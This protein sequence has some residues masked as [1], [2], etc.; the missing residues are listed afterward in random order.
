MHSDILFEKMDRTI[1]L[2]KSIDSKLPD[3]HTGFCFSD[4]IAGD[5]HQLMPKP[6]S[7]EISTATKLKAVK[8]SYR[9][10]IEDF[11]VSVTFGIP[12]LELTVTWIGDG[13]CQVDRH[14][15]I[16]GNKVY[17]R[18]SIDEVLDTIISEGMIIHDVK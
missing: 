10:L 16:I 1:E 17:E 3:T 15:E 18:V 14:Q 6:I 5:V 8:E 12:H 11:A 2:L 4:A 7:T 13:L 9:K